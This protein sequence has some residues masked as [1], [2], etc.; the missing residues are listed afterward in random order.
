[1]ANEDKVGEVG[2]MMLGL[3]LKCLFSGFKANDLLILS[4]LSFSLKW[5]MFDGLN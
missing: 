1:M 4:C 2:D 5:T 3:M